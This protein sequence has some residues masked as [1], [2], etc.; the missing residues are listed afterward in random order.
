MKKQIKKA[1]PYLLYCA[2]PMLLLTSCGV[3]YDS[4]KFSELLADTSV[5]NDTLLDELDENGNLQYDENLSLLEAADRLETYINICQKID[6]NKIDI[7]DDSNTLSEKE[8]QSIENLSEDDI[9]N[10]IKYASYSGSNFEKNADKAKA[11][12]ILSNLKTYCRDWINKNGREVSIK[13]MINSVKSSIADEE[14][15]DISE[16]ENITIPSYELAFNS[17]KSF[18]VIVD[19]KNISICTNVI[20]DT[21][22]YIYMLQRMSNDEVTDETCLEA[23][24]R[25]KETMVY[26]CDINDNKA[27]KQNSYSYVK[28]LF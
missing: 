21:I 17:G 11:I 27:N 18:Y 28:T 15:L 24:E 8:I 5:K 9:D 23:L 12:R 22:D 4:K 6:K 13:I 14:N 10:L 3:K 19:D 25:A 26:G 1:L 20:G 2:T 7:I 16:Y